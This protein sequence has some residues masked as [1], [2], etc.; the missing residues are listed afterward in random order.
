MFQQTPYMNPTSMQDVSSLLAHHQGVIRGY[1]LSLTADPHATNDVLQ[2][3]NLVICKKAETFSRGTNF[4]GW[5]CRIAYFEVL[6]HRANSS[7]DK[8]VFDNALLEE[9]SEE[10]Q[11]E[12]HYYEARKQAL[13]HC[14]GLMS[15]Q[16]KQLILQ[17]YYENVPLTDIAA[18]RNTNPNAISQLLY[19]LRQ[20]LM[21]CIERTQVEN[22]KI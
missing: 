9:I 5:A 16:N 3:T 10:A 14:L 19:R 22:K 17:R 7:R 4:I 18:K 20:Q 1:I 11:G 15:K 2:E 13:A 12:C 6:R 8:L 21:S